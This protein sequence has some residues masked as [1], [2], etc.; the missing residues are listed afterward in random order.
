MKVA[1]VER[2]LL[3][4]YDP[5]LIKEHIQKLIGRIGKYQTV[6]LSDKVLWA[7]C[8]HT[9][10]NS[11]RGAFVIGLL[12]FCGHSQ[13]DTIGEL[14]DSFILYFSLA[15][16]QVHHYYSEALPTTALILCWT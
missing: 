1:E 3:V 12:T 11:K 16:L 4:T 2:E 14:S 10:L 7:F 13:S 6:F 5:N 8:S 9:L 15:P